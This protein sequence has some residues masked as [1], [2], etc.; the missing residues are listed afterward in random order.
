MENLSMYGFIKRGMRLKKISPKE[1]P[2]IIPQNLHDKDKF[3]EEQESQQN[4][5]SIRSDDNNSQ[6]KQSHEQPSPSNEQISENSDKNVLL[7]EVYF[8]SLGTI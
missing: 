1:N 7:Y 6:E 5:P 4:S 3:N 8:F 2:S